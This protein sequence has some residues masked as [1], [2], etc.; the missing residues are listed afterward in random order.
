[1]AQAA[2]ALNVSPRSVKHYAHKT[3]CLGRYFRRP[4]DG[5]RHPSIPASVLLWSQVL[6]Y[7]L[8]DPSYLAM[9]RLS[10][11][12]AG[13]ALGIPR[14]FGDDAVGYFTERLDPGPTRRA[15]AQVLG[16]AKRN[17]AFD[18]H[19]CIGLAL[20]GTGAGRSAQAHCALCRPFHNDQKEIAGYNHHVVAITVV[21]CGLTLPFDAEPYGPGD[22]EYNAGQRLVKRAVSCLGKRFA[23]YVVVDGEFATAPFLHAANDAGLRVV[24]RLKENL[25]ELLAQARH[26]FEHKPPQHIFWDSAERIEMWDADDFDPWETLSWPTVRVFRYRQHKTDGSVVDAYWL[27][28]LPT[29]RVAARTL[30]RFA[31]NR[32]EVEN[33]VFNDGKNRFGFEHIPHHEANSLL[34][35]WLLIFLAL[36]IERLYRLRYLHRGTHPSLTSM[37]LLRRL[38]LSMAPPAVI[39]PG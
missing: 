21:G 20:D 8:R 19:R 5:R 7:V 38:R 34:L 9:E 2:A 3:L 17:K 28:D 10:K 6:G 16:R 4:G 35:H 26:R 1:M 13:R 14:T 12:G 11:S 39:D 29:K 15:L 18:A 24:A 32:W 31:K 36:C 25:P 37:D 23:T 27:T 30:Y 33:L 22:C